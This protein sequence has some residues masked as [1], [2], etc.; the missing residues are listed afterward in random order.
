M[1]SSATPVSAERA[2]LK[3]LV[4]VALMEWKERRETR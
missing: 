2:P 1:Q 4:R 3:E